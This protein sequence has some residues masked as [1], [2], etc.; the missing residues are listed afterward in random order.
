MRDHESRA[1][2]SE[3]A[4][5]IGVATHVRSA[6]H[7]RVVESRDSNARSARQLYGTQ[8]VTRDDS[9]SFGCPR[10]FSLSHCAA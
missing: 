10:R 2:N 1:E 8:P 3:I 5:Q 9:Y 4:M 7:G 6:R